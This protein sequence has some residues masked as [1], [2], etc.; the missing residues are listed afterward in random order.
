MWFMVMSWLVS[1][2]LSSLAPMWFMVMTWLVSRDLILPIV[3]L[4][5]CKNAN[6]LFDF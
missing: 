5:K 2:D 3:L 4:R 1:R 6:Y